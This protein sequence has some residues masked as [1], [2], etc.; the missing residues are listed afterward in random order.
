MISYRDRY[1]ENHSI[2]WDIEHS[3]C[4][5]CEYRKKQGCQYYYGRCRQGDENE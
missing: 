2:E 3:A 1:V 4:K 5:N